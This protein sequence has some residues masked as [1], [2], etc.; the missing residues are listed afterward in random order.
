M[1]EVAAINVPTVQNIPARARDE[2]LR[3]SA[4]LFRAIADTVEGARHLLPWQHVVLE[5]NLEKEFEEK[6]RTRLELHKHL[7]DAVDRYSHGKPLR[8]LRGATRSGR[9]HGSGNGRPRRRRDGTI[10]TS[11]VASWFWLKCAK[12]ERNG[13]LHTPQQ[14]TGASSRTTAREHPTVQR[15]GGTT[16]YSLNACFVPATG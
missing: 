5:A 7:C 3:Q 13:N 11:T 15:H 2:Y 12:L 8:L 1:A 10:L 9:P 4:R 14:L 6:W 16:S